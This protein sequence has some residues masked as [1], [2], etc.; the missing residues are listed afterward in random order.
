MTIAHSVC[1]TFG[2]LIPS[3]DVPILANRATFGNTRR[4]RSLTLTDSHLLASSFR[5]LR[6]TPQGAAWRNLISTHFF[7]QKSRFLTQTYPTG[8]HRQPT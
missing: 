8:T 7:R 3:N 4:A 1:R 2:C 5:L 6:L